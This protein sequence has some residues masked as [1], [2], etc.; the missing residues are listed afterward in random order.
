MRKRDAKSVYIFWWFIFSEKTRWHICQILSRRTPPFEQ[1][2]NLQGL[3]NSLIKNCAVDISHPI[4]FL[5]QAKRRD[6]RLFRN[7][8]SQTYSEQSRS[9]VAQ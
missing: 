4:S 1:R 3:Q 5:K 8:R 7:I 2:S 6:F 9:L